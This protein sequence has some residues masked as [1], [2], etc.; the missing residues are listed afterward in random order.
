VKKSKSLLGLLFFVVLVL[1]AAA[2]GSWATM[3][4]IEG[5]YRT[6][7]KPAWNPPNSIFGPVWTTLYLMMAVAAWIVWKQ[8]AWKVVAL[9]LS[10]FSIQLLLNVAWSWIFFS[11][12]Q[13]GWAAVEIFLLW[14]SIAATVICFF[15]HSKI[16]AWLMIPYMAWVTFASILNVAIWRMNIQ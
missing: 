6:L 11:L 7:N 5:W 2:L 10:L 4:E 8:G 9:P 16:A 13:P 12:H 3:P 14:L 15:R 1:A